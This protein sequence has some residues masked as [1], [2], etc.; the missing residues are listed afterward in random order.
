MTA[1]AT[2]P[3]EIIN[4]EWISLSPSSRTSGGI[5]GAIIIS[6]TMAMNTLKNKPKRIVPI[7]VCTSGISGGERRFRIPVQGRLSGSPRL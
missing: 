5:T 7:I 2:E 1:I 3:S 4:P 6:P